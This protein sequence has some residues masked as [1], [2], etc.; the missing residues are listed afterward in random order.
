MP[1]IVRVPIV[2]ELVSAG[3]SPPGLAMVSPGRETEATA[4]LATAFP[5]SFTAGAVDSRSL[6]VRSVNALRTLA[7]NRHRCLL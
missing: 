7:G 1:L 3:C 5:L 6:V 2:D 4:T